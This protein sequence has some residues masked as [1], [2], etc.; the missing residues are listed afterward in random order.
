MFQELEHLNQGHPGRL[1]TC[2]ASPHFPVFPA[3]KYPVGRHKGGGA[4][5]SARGAPRS[6]ARRVPGPSLR[7]R[8]PACGQHADSEGPGRALCR[9]PAPPRPTH[10]ERAVTPRA[11][12]PPARAEGPPAA[13][14]PKALTGLPSRVNDDRRRLRGLVVALRRLRGVVGA[15]W[16]PPRA[17]CV[18]ALLREAGTAAEGPTGCPQLAGPASC[19][20]LLFHPRGRPPK[21]LPPLGPREERRN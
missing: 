6:S 11:E 7:A 4:G 9:C 12:S 19:Q 17:K 10:D 21:S 8:P 13:A 1:G 2:S 20:G 15:H 16:T 5:G 18:A 14:Q 3:N